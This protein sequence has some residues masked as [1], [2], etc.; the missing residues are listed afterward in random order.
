M[1][2]IRLDS[3]GKSIDSS[4][5]TVIYKQVTHLPQI[6]NIAR[7]LVLAVTPPSQHYAID[8]YCCDYCVAVEGRPYR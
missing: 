5:K 1:D 8:F 6:Y 2:R 3:T 7:Y 4:E